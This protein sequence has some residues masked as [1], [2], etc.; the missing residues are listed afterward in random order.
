MHEKPRFSFYSRH[1]KHNV[2]RFFL[3]DE[4]IPALSQFG[5]I[6]QAAL[7]DVDAV[8]RAGSD[9]RNA[10]ARGTAGHLGQS[11]HARALRLNLKKE[12]ERE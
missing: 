2:F 3:T 9:I 1:H 12:R 4:L 7:H 10:L 8:S 11:L 5:V 6:R